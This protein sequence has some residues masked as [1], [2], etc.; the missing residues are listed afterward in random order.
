M[1]AHDHRGA[2]S[3][4]FDQIVPAEGRKAA[5]DDGH[6]ARRVEKRHLPNRIAKH[7]LDAVERRVRMRVMAD[8]RPARK[9]QP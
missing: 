4:G 1:R 2:H 9:A 3:A 7:H 5:P 6:T 8:L